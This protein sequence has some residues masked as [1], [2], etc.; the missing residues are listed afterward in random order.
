MSAAAMIATWGAA[1]LALSALAAWGQPGPLPRLEQVQGRCH[2]MVDGEPY[3]ALAGQA[4]NSSATN[5]EDIER[6]CKA[7]AAI[8]GNTLIIPSY[9]ELVE[10]QPGQFDFSLVDEVIAAA[11]H[12]GLR[13]VLQWFATWK[14]GE[15]NYTP[16]WVKRDRAQHRRARGLWGEELNV[17]SPLSRATRAADARAFAALLQHIGAVDQAQRTVIMVQVE[18]EPG[19]MGTDR[20]YSQAANRLFNGGVPQSL[21][22]YLEQHRDALSASMRA[23]WGGNGFRRCGTWSEVFGGLAAEAFSAWHIARYI[24]RVAAAG[25]KAYP[26]PM[27]VNA[28]LVEAHVERPGRWPSGGPTEHVLDIWKAAAPHI[29]LIAPDIYYPKYYENAVHYARPDNPL[30]VPEVNFLPFFGA[31]AFMTFADFNGI[32]FSPFGIDDAL[33]GEQLHPRAAEFEDTYRVLRPLLP[34]IARCQYTGKL[35][36][37]I[38]GVG[39]GEGWA[40]AI[41]LASNTVAA[42]IEFTVAFDPERGRGRGIVMELGPDDFIFAGAGFKVTFR[43][44]R[45]PLREAKIAWVEEG[46]FEGERWVPQRR[47][48]GDEAQVRL[49]EQATIVRVRLAQ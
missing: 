17:I 25:K 32:C 41:P 44:L 14:N 20:D 3:L 19:L 39:R 23:A 22:S 28:W 18:N 30:F 8:H 42:M 36:S 15:M 31:F 48:S 45:G 35:H 7:V 27:Y 49:P 16:E 1:L 5:R 2:L 37:I 10:P 21:M 40:H 38:Q 34:L 9:W 24:D 26:L 29:D 11:R 4:H 13:V 12:H 46:A 33:D 6:A 43:E 47:W